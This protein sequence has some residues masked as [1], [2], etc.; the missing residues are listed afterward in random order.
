MAET[1][2]G[3]VKGFV[4]DDPLQRIHRVDV[5]CAYVDVTTLTRIVRDLITH[6]GFACEVVAVHEE[7][8]GWRVTVRH[9]GHGLVTF[10]VPKGTPSQVREDIVN[11]LDAQS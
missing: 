10:E 11:R 9:R 3:F 5:C 1:A 7:L 2:L 8:G 4:R 6:R